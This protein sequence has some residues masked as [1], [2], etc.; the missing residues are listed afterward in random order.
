MRKFNPE[1]LR[2]EING[3]LNLRNEIENIVD[4][5]CSE[6]FKNIYWIG[7]GGTYASA[8][9]TYI[10]MKEKSSLD[11]NFE[12]ASEYLTTGNKRIGKNTIAVISSESGTTDE[13]VRAVKKLKKEGVT[14]LGFIDTPNTPL[15]EMVDY[16]VS[17]FSYEQ[18]K[19]YMVADRFM[20]NHG[21][22]DDY[23]EYYEEMEKH[24]ADAL[25]KVEE[26]ADLFGKTF[27]LKHHKDDMHYFVGAG[28]MMGATYSYA[29]CYWE[30]QH[31][32]RT[33]SIH[34]A[35]FIHGCF[36]I[37]DRDSNVTIFVGED[38]QRILSE[39]IVKLIP[40]ICGNYNIIDTKDYELKGISKKYRG[41]ISH[42][43]MRRICNR[44]DVYIEEI[45]CH[46]M[47][48]RRYYR[49]IDY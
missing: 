7:I 14:I 16:C 46:P 17:Y 27:A 2:S 34:A 37:I 35:E 31:W 36:E 21:E 1:K 30:E 45:N 29:M 49:Q 6:G 10:H 20:Y 8:H 12:N 3:A 13:M 40:K 42:L 39:R 18:I 48:I 41:S 24:L 44:I 26:D 4:K 19:F 43:V 11:I 32:L 47:E 38:S 15:F 25:V 28:N 33:K 9:Q 23:Y 22:F 5:L